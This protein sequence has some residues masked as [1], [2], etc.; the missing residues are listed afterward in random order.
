MIL[1]N[2]SIR[3]VIMN[4]NKELRKIALDYF[5]DYV[6]FNTEADPKSGLTPSSEGQKVLAHRLAD[7]LRNLGLEVTISDYHYVYGKLDANNEEL[8]DLPALGFISHMDT[9]PDFSGD[10]V[11]PRI[12]NYQGG[13]IILDKEEDIKIEES[14][15][16][17]LKNLYGEDLV[18]TNG[19]SL[20]GADDKSGIAEIMT[21]FAY[22]KDHPE[23][24]HGPLRVCFTPDEEI[25]EGTKF[26]DLDLF[27]CYYAY[28]MDGSVIGELEYENFNAAAALIKVEGLS[29]HPGTAKNKLVNAATIASKFVASMNEF[30]TPEHSEGREGFFHLGG[31]SGSVTEA[32]IEYIIRDFDKESFEARKNKLQDLVDKINMDLDKDRISL[33]I[34]D[35]YYNM[36][37]KVETRFELI[38]RARQAMQEI[39]VKP[40]EEAIRG[41]TD[42]AMLS[43]KGLPCPNIFTG[44]ANFHGRYEYL[45]ISTMEKAIE[46]LIKLV[47]IYAEAKN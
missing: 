31:I 16:P 33:S 10:N 35:Q 12:I 24:S 36:K 41:G 47:S 4:N 14:L 37:E 34:R 9:S 19:H 39:G 17:E 43:W 38:E 46:F 44:G 45:V 20:L 7:D 40:K 32:E 11:S 13:D 15:F 28:T 22:L 30:D 6:K 8:K 29:V 27:D 1:N 18:V 5:L 23:F 21:L 3:G 2:F 42:G 26:F 25:G